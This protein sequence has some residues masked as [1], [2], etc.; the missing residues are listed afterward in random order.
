MELEV[1]SFGLNFLSQRKKVVEEKVWFS[2]DP[3]FIPVFIAVFIP[4]F[5]KP[6]SLLQMT[7]QQNSR[8]P[9]LRT[10]ITKILEKNTCD[11]LDHPLRPPFVKCTNGHYVCGSCRPQLTNDECPYC[12]VPLSTVIKDRILDEIFF[13]VHPT[14]G[15]D[16]PEPPLGRGANRSLSAT[17]GPSRLPRGRGYLLSQLGQVDSSPPLPGRGRQL[18][19]SPSQNLQRTIGRSLIEAA[20]EES[21]WNTLDI[22]DAG[23][24]FAR[25][26]VRR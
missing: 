17:A 25:V 23:N 26:P 13:A 4:V 10:T 14:F 5:I 15:S 18:G 22:D 19:Q 3:V 9:P 21:L 20:F 7:E 16:D 24:L 2:V 1:F 6:L 12:R 11:I 8:K